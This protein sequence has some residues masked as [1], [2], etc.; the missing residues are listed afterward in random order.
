MACV[1]LA[2]ST[3]S[4]PLR[5]HTVLFPSPSDRPMDAGIGAAALAEPGWPGTW[6]VS[7]L[8]Q[9]GVH[10]GVHSSPGRG[11]TEASQSHRHC[12]LV[13]LTE[14]P[15][16]PCVLPLL[17]PALAT[18]SLATMEP[19]CGES[20]SGCQRPRNDARADPCRNHSERADPRGNRPEPAT[21][22][23][24]LGTECQFPFGSSDQ[25]QGWD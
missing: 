11:W 23:P 25:S 2:V 19:R 16:G 22:S 12:H 14:E 17:R 13:R 24:A 18:L 1:G 21:K 7:G 15:Q 8:A 3:L 20:R 4:N 9:H 10:I 5:T 6:G